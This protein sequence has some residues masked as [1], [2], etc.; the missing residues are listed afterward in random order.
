MARYKDFFGYDKLFVAPA[1]VVLF[2]NIS[3]LV[4]NF[5]SLQFH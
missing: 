3:L 2:F 4:V 5:V 1:A